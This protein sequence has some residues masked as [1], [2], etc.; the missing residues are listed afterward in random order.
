MDSANTEII[1]DT[2]FWLEDPISLSQNAEIL[3]TG[4]QSINERYNAMT[5]LLLILLVIAYLSDVKP[6]HI[7]MLFI[8]GLLIIIFMHERESGNS[9][10]VENFHNLGVFVPECGRDAAMVNT[11]NA[12][13]ELTPLI[14]YNSDNASKRSY[15]NARFEVIPEYVPAPYSEAWRNESV[16]LDPYTMTPDPYTVN[17]DVLEGD[18]PMSQKNYI[19]RSSVD[20][21]PGIDSS[22]GLQS[23]RAD[24]ESAFMRDSTMHR[25]TIIGEHID[26]FMR[27]R[28]NCGD[29]R[30][31]KQTF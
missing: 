27:E 17:S 30:S 7:G 21:L 16:D 3:P 26:R 4:A 2:K 18:L 29:V 11:I 1:P 8:V 14:R 6:E 25:D 19:T 10:S 22:K 24:V 23:I 31:G 9:D 13:Y 12:K 20:L 28:G 15:N 5:K